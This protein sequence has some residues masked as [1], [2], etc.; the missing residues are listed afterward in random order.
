MKQV[1]IFHIKQ[2]VEDYFNLNIDINTRRREVVQA[3]QIAQHFTLKLLGTKRRGGWIVDTTG[4]GSGYKRGLSLAYIGEMIGNKDH[5]TVLHA[6]K[7]INNLIETDKSFKLLMYDI[8]AK[9]NCNDIENFCS[10]TA[11]L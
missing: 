2:T 3:R 8:E 5:A 10:N 4:K 1:T 6:N 9:I 7:A 11:Q